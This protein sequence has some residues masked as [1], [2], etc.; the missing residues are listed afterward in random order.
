MQLPIDAVRM[1]DITDRMRNHIELVDGV[2]YV[3]VHPTFLYESVW[4]L[5]LLAVLFFYRRCKKFEGELFLVYLLGYGL[6]RMWI[7]GLRTDK[8]LIPALN[9]PVSQMLAGI[10][11][12]VALVLIVYNRTQ[13]DKT[14]LRR[15]REREAK[16]GSRSSRNMFHGK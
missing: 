8:L 1:S 9:I 16:R 4:C 15:M 3:K 13:D 7:E 10:T 5:L 14:R 12:V 6:G 2:R 11:V